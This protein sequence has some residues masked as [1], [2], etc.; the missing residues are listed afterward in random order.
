V[1]QASVHESEDVPS[2]IPVEIVWM[3]SAS[4]E[5]GLRQKLYYML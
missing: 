4:A 3:D 1:E 5:N 2:D